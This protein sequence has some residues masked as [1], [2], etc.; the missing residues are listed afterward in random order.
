MRLFENSGFVE[1]VGGVPG[2]KNRESLRK[3]NRVSREVP[4]TVYRVQPKRLLW[5][6]LN[7]EVFSESGILKQPL[8]F[9]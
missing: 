3:T 9:Y 2:P 6:F 8:N 7:N 4:I 1:P 5:Y